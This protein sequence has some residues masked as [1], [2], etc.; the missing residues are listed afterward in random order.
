M[1]NVV[2][3]LLNKDINPVPDTDNTIELANSFGE[4]FIGK[5]NK[6]RA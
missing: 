6:I 3:E 1:Y 4:F 2:K 5:V